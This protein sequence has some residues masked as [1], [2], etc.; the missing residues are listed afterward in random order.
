MENALVNQD[1]AIIVR[2]GREQRH[3]SERGHMQSHGGAQ[4]A[5]RD[6]RYEG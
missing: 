1:P 4:R 6:H 5:K 3:Y 2:T